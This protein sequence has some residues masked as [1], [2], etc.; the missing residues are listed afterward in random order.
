[1]VPKLELP[2][3]LAWGG[4]PRER[5][6]VVSV[7][8]GEPARGGWAA[9]P[10]PV[11]EQAL[12][13]LWPRVFPWSAA[14]SRFAE[15]LRARDGAMHPLV[16]VLRRL[17]VQTGRGW[18]GLTKALLAGWGDVDDPV[19]AARAMG[20][21]VAD[22]LARVGPETGPPGSDPPG[23]AAVSAAPAV[24]VALDTL[25]TSPGVYFLRDEAGDLLYVGKAMSLRDRVP[26][27]FRAGAPEEAKRR[28]LA[29]TREVH[30]EET[31]SEL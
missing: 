20:D 27:H 13:L 29:P 16:T 7:A 3:V 30:W 17:G 23:D 1:M 10:D 28:R 24:R 6:L 21:V 19:E 18:E 25:P 22:L 12:L 8:P 14:S 31:G 4:G 5:D 11:P 9:W 26:Q 2:L 15:T